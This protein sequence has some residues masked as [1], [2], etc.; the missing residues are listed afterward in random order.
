MSTSAAT[1]ASGFLFKTNN[2]ADNL[3]EQQRKYFH[4]TVVR[5]IFITKRA[6]P[7]IHTAI[8]YLSKIFK[9]TNTNDWRKLSCIMIQLMET[10]D[11]VLR[12]KVEYLNVLKC[13]IDASYTIH[14][15]IKGNT[16]ASLS[17]GVGTLNT[18]CIKQK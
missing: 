14:H 4:T 9:E 2:N 6:R 7:D 17:M 8:A 16:G 10:K 3:K 18:K 12:L 15:N 11:L 13:H 1:P 5:C